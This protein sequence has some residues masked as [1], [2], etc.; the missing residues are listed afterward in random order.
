[1]AHERLERLGWRESTSQITT[2]VDET[3]EIRQ[4]DKASNS[5]DALCPLR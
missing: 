1:L 2:R 5:E 4:L 3:G